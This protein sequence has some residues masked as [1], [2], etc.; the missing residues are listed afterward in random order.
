MDWKRTLFSFH[1]RV[2]RST[3]WLGTLGLSAM[4]MLANS[5]AWTALRS[6]VPREVMQNLPPTSVITFFTVGLAFAW[7]IL[8]IQAKRWHDVDK[9]AWWI[10]VN[11][12]PVIG[13]VVTFV[14]CGLLPGTPGVNRFGPPD[15]SRMPIQETKQ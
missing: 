12:G 2:G 7:P 4:G 11:L 3:F 5:L 6:L 15:R 13:G 14:Y 8:A 9:S 1:G 10:L